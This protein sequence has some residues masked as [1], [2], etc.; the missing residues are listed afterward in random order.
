MIYKMY[1]IFFQLLVAAIFLALGF[2]NIN[3][4]GHQKVNKKL[5]CLNSYPVN[6]SQS[7]QFCQI[8]VRL[9]LIS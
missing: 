4:E 6:W 8:K 1:S 3:E 5:S 7:N 9:E 2:F